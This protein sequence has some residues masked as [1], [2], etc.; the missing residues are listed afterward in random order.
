[1]GPGEFPAHRGGVRYNA[2][3]SGSPPDL[4]CLNRPEEHGQIRKHRIWTHQHLTCTRIH[5][6]QLIQ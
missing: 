6:I 4:E 2:K 3:Q 1:M 5:P